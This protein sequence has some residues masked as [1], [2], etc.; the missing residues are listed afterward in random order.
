V[1][2]IPRP[3]TKLLSQECD[4]DLAI[5]EL[6]THSM[7]NDEV[8]DHRVWNR[9]NGLGLIKEHERENTLEK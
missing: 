3:Q 5:S 1:S 9:M 8:P 7:E 2:I 4:N 6:P